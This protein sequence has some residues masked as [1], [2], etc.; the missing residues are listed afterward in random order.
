MMLCV[1]IGPEK[2]IMTK[3]LV[4][5]VTIL[6]LSVNL[7]KW[8][9]WVLLWIEA[10]FALLP[11]DHNWNRLMNKKMPKRSV[12]QRFPKFLKTKLYLKSAQLL[13]SIPFTAY[14]FHCQEASWAC[15]PEIHRNCY[16]YSIIWIV[17]ELIIW[18][19]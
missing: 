12:L 16:L 2:I 10:S 11:T 3:Y 18:T 4:A 7:P 13:Y 14:F 5:T 15:T 8:Q 9:Q 17:I 1:T 6:D 19:V